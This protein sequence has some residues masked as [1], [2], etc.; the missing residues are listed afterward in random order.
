MRAVSGLT[1]IACLSVSAA[2]QQPAAPAPKVDASQVL[3]GAREALGGEARLA[4]VKTFVATGRTRQVR[5]D[6]LLPIEFEIVS[7]LPDKFVRK[8]EI[9]AQ[10]SGPTSTGFNGEELIQLPVPAAPPAGGP[11]R[12]AGPGA[13]PGGAPPGAPG[14]GPQAPP[15]GGR[16]A[17]IK[18][19]FARLTLGMF[20]TSFASFPLTF[21]HAGLAEAP[22]GE[23]DV[24]DV[25]GP[26]NFSVRYFVDRKTHLPIMLSWQVPATN[27]IVAIPGQPPPTVP[28]GAIVVD[29][30]PPP[31]ATASKE[32]QDAYGQAVAGL[33]KKALA[34]A[35]PIE[36][37][38]YYSDY[39]AVDGFQFPFRLRRAVAGQTIEETTFDR[40]RINTKIDPRRFEVR[41]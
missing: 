27:V 4:G 10:E 19:D 14:R 11:P 38:V 40:F 21:T 15:P 26:G 30:P 18:Q 37:R 28:P 24:L 41:K 39:R 13:P 9:P 3:A 22:Q 23:A 29:A 35:K 32:E 8:D 16:T 31:A 36:H 25:K 5:G 33:R 12:G 7:E 17:T 1:L 6:N 20:A 34:E 2:D